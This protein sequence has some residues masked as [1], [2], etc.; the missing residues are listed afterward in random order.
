VERTDGAALQKGPVESGRVGQ[1]PVVIEGG[2]GV[3]RLVHPVQAVEVLGHDI[4]CRHRTGPQ[5]GQ[6]VAGG[7]FGRGGQAPII[8]Y[9]RRR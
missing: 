2:G 5:A 3:G 9:R 8:A 4:G 7:R 1:R 6:E